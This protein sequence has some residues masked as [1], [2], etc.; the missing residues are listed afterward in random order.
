MGTGLLPLCQPGSLGILGAGRGMR[1]Q[2]GP[3]YFKMLDP[4][5]ATSRAFVA[6]NIQDG[7][8]QLP[9]WSGWAAESGAHGLQ[10]P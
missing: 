7:G 8:A 4:L 1:A 10:N 3:L 2:R 6:E 5:L 9:A